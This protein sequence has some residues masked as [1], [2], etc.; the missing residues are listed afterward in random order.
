MSSRPRA[1]ITPSTSAP[2]VVLLLSVLFTG[3]CRKEPPASSPSPPVVSVMEV[4]A[5]DVAVSAEY[6]AQTQSSHL[7]N[8]QARV[9]GFLDRRMYTEGAVV[10]EG[11]VL[12]QMDAKPFQV[13]LDQAKAALVQQRP[14][15]RRPA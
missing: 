9:S 15:S 7:V 12:F 10:K 4:V 3:A 14:R 6:V 1:A 8:I 11:Q 13:Q 2:I 5:K